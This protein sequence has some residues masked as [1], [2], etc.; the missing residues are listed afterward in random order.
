ML[1]LDFS[2]GQAVKTA[3]QYRDRE[4]DPWLGISTGHEVWPERKKKS[5]ALG[6][7]H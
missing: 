4:L 5:V 1:H 3:P 6:N 2:G 7:A